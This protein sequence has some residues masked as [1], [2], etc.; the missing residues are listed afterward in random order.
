MNSLRAAWL[1]A[2]LG[3]AVPSLRAED[4]KSNVS[5]GT[6]D[7]SRI[8][9][10]IHQLGD[11]E[12]VER[13][14]AITELDAI[15]EPALELLHGAAAHSDLEV[16]KNA[17][18]LVERIVA[19]RTIRLA[20]ATKTVRL[21]VKD[22]T[23]YD[24]VEQLKEKTGIPITLGDPGN[25]KDFWTSKNGRLTLD[26]GETTCW[27]ALDQL[28]RKAGVVEK[29]PVWLPG[30]FGA[31]TIALHDGYDVGLPPAGITLAPG[32]MPELCTADLG[33]VRVRVI[34]TKDVGDQIM[35]APDG[36]SAIILD[37]LADPRLQ[38]FQVTAPP[39]LDTAVDDQKRALSMDFVSSNYWSEGALGDGEAVVGRRV[40][41]RRGMLI[42]RGGRAIQGDVLNNTNRNTV[43][44][45]LHLGDK[46]ATALSELSGVIPVR[47][48][49]PPEPIATVD[50]ILKAAGQ[51]FPGDKSGEVEIKAVDKLGN[52]DLRVQLV[53]TGL[54][55]QDLVGDGR[56]RPVQQARG[57]RRLAPE[58]FD[59]AR[60]DMPRVLDAQGK[61]CELVE[62]QGQKTENNGGAMVETMT[63]VYHPAE[64][65]SE[66]TR[67]V[68]E[69]RRLTSFCVPFT[70]K[71]VPL[72]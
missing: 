19:R 68:V 63:L 65:G 67:L 60:E 25:D 24:A 41:A 37:V 28:C 1:V 72:R 34:P 50:G 40:I 6:V 7:K 64:S 16:A 71:N 10:L 15:G 3:V 61:S 18:D 20:L 11:D 48:L 46:S 13:R 2:F 36:E 35:A 59:R 51:K 66:P 4:P 47:A 44:I 52:G 27:D 5:P 33:A 23:L 42:A 58:Y 39:C 14:K 9:R 26:T 57:R 17:R 31:N 69:G 8:E 54:L 49:T 55:V 30:Q 70:L 38:Y 43:P 12:F 56:Q 62:V 53:L 45:Y 32:K 29:V 22:V 21:N